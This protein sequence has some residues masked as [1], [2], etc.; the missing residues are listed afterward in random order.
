MKKAIKIGCIALSIILIA[1]LVILIFFPGLFTYFK[2]KHDYESIDATSEKFEY[3][4]VPDDFKY[5]TKNGV[6][7]AKP[8]GMEEG[9]NRLV[10]L[11]I[12]SSISRNKEILEQAGVYTEGTSIYDEEFSEKEYGEYFKKLE[13]TAPRDSTERLFYIK[14]KL[15]AKDC[16]HLRGKN[17]EI[18]RNFA[19]I[20]EESSKIETTYILN[21]PEY[22]AYASQVNG[23]G[24]DGNL[25]T[26]YI[27]QHDDDDTYY[28]V[29]VKNSNE[30]IV[31]QVISSIEITEE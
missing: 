2:V 3:A 29:M 1:A 30:T 7:Y 12:K 20:K 27:Y 10:V 19:D 14:T 17:M 18:F 9:D 22:D 23:M 21:I 5:Y 28:N 15:K 8:D 25:W 11:P 13:Q 31:K 4:D 16:L 26:V 6:S 24:Y